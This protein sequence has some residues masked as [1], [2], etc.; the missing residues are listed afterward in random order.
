MAQVPSNLIP[1]RIT[2][3]MTDPAPSTD[4]LVMYVRDGVTYNVRVADLL[5][6]SIWALKGANADITSM[7]GLTGGLS[8]PDFVQFDTAATPVLGVGKLQWDAEYGTL[9]FGLTGGNVNLQVGQEQ[10]QHVLNKTGSTLSDGK[11]VIVT[12][13]Q[14]QR[15]TVA[16]AQADSDANSATV[17]GILTED[18]AN[19][20]QGYCTTEGLVHG[21]DTSA[22]AEG[23]VLYLSG[24]V[25]G[26][27]TNVKP[28][29]PTH[30]VMIGY[31]VKSHHVDGHIMVKVQNGYELDELHD[32]K[33]TSVADKDFLQYD[34]SVPA[35]VNTG[36]PRLR[37]YTVATLPAAG[38]LGRIAC[39]TDATAPTYLG[40]L[41]GGGA[42]RVPVFDN[43]TNWVAI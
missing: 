36:T 27:L 41:T 26:G 14:G 30:L 22:F 40:T 42:V 13:A 29:A 4:G 25:P 7:T 17:L 38:T 10:V 28:Q 2:Q 9:Q 43:G 37:S 18:I 19:N 33:L 32:V 20:Q 15:T 24:T 34:S 11:V 31:C 12:G 21:V 35:W 1:V 39:V 8:S 6:S 5:Q 3:L 23:D 16:Y